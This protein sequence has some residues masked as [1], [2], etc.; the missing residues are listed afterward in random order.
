MRIRRGPATVT[1]ERPARMPLPRSGGKAE[2]SADP[3]AR[4]LRPPIL[5]TRGVVTPRK[6]PPDGALVWHRAALGF[7]HRPAGRPGG[8]ARPVSPR[9]T[10]PVSPAAKLAQSAESSPGEPGGADW[11]LA[12]PARTAAADLPALLDGAFCVVVRLLG[13]RR[14]WP[15]GLDAVLASGLPAVVLSGEP[16]PDAELM[17]LS[18]VPAGVATEALAYLREGGPRNLAQLARFLSDTILLTGEGFDPPEVL[19]EYGR[20]RPHGERPRLPGRPAVGIVFYRSHA[21]AGNTAFADTLADAVEACGASA[22]P[23][24]CGSLR[25]A[26]PEFYDLLEGVDAVIVTVLAAGGTV[27]ADASAG[28]DD[29]AWDVAALAALD[30]PVLQALCLTTPRATWAASTAALTPMDAAMQVAVPE[31]DGRLITVPF[32]FKEAGP[33]GVPGLHR[34]PGA[35][36]PGGRHRG[37]ARPAPAHPG[38]GPAAGHHA[39]LLPDQ[40]RPDRQRGRAGHPRVGRDPAPG[41]ARGRLRPGRGVPRR[42]RHPDP[43]ADRGGR[44][45]H[46]VADR[47]PARGRDPAGAA[48][49]V[50]A[51][52]RR[53]AARPAGRRP[54]AL[55]R[56]ARPAL[57][58]PRRHRAGRA[59]VRERDRDDPAAARVRREPGGHLPRPRPA[60]LASLPGRLPLAGS[61]VPRGRGRAPGQARHAGMAARQGPGP[62][63]GLR[64]RRG[65]AGTC[66]WST[67]SSSTT[68]ARAPRPSGAGTPPSSTT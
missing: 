9:R 49:R 27:A 31:F 43:P 57:H 4:K 5:R 37:G 40:A 13:G 35:G 60:A 19:P 68:P 20:T 3:G 48:G 54:G 55:G 7:G 1:G 56:A 8:E 15:E 33:D 47:R 44:A 10:R 67:R 24:F 28:G 16:A 41:A 30:V 58:R 63:R 66:R 18:T 42:R 61:R 17:S 38:R 34:R 6:A 26:P 25:A 14:S 29:D 62:V 50:R 64:A 59:A 65:P 51:M 52:V 53:A 23:V 22:V 39:V 12:N 11:R 36:R 2:G 45:G 32:S 46:R 21:V